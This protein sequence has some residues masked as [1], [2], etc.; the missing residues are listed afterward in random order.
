M[1]HDCTNPTVVAF[2]PGE[3]LADLVV[4]AASRAPERPLFSRAVGGEWVDVTAA[5]WRD[6]V[7]DVAKGLMESGIQPGDRVA[8][9]SRTR[10]EWTLLDFAIWSVGAVTVPIY[11]TSSAEQVE[12]ILSDS[13]AVAVVVETSTHAGLIDLA[14]GSTPDLEHTWVIDDDDVVSLMQ[15]GAQLTDSEVRQRAAGVT[16]D[17]LATLIYTSGTTGRPKGVELTHHNLLFDARSAVTALDALFSLADGSTLLFLPLAHVFARAIQVACVDAGIRLGH[18]TDVKDLP[19]QLQSFAP[20]FVLSVPR[21]FE[22]VYN[23]ARHKAITEGK[24]RI[25]DA[26]AT[27]AISFSQ[28]Q[29]AGHV[30]WSLRT[31]HAVFDRLVYGKLRAALGGQVDWAVSGGAALGSRLGHFFCGAGITILEGYG[32]TETSAAATVNTP[33]HVR[34]GT[35]GRPLPGTTIRI[36]GDGE[37]LIRG[38]Q[39]MVGY[40]HN[41]EATTS[42]LTADGWFRSGDLGE[43]DEDGYLSITGR[44]KEIIVTAGGKNV[45]P[46]VLEDR[47]RGHWLIS[48]AMVVG[49]A[50]PYIAALIT[51]DPEALP[52]WAQRARQS[53]KA[54]AADAAK[55]VDMRI[56]CEDPDLLAEIQTAVDDANRAVS[57]AEAIKRFRVL[58]V[59]FTEDDG[60]LTPTMKLRRNVVLAEFAADVEALYA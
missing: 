55:A 48:Q 29:Q 25:F 7:F 1:T 23:S 27:T 38:P 43:F 32:L 34:I 18:C 9:M 17:S 56:L 54:D 3:T 35:V 12:W 57:H 44:K 4:A 60:Q 33:D 53:T 15:V 28:A 47:L 59:D 30:P 16:P 6:D 58:A 39:V 41:P 11:E 42:A 20:T 52:R 37:V 22:K 10:Y 26:A 21:V 50:R 46:A 51:L 8:L 5:A 36:A 24:G 13:G 40:W 31:R 49:D 14:R 19:A 45:A 2:E